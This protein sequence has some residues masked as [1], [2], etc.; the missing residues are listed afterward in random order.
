MSCVR[1]SVAKHGTIAAFVGGGSSLSCWFRRRKGRFRLLCFPTKEND[2]WKASD[3]Q[4]M[5]PA[6]QRQRHGG[7]GRV[8]RR[9]PIAPRARARDPPAP[10]QGH[11]PVLPMRQTPSWLRPG[12]RRAS[13]ASSGFRL[14]EGRTGR[15]DAARG[16]PGM[17]RRGRLRAV[18]GAGQPVHQGF[19][20]G[21][22]VADDGR[23]PEDGRRFPSY[24]V[25]D[26]GRR[27][28]SGR[29]TRQGVDALAVRR[30]DGDR[31]GRDQLQEG[32]R[33]WPWSSTTSSIG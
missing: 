17:R 13:L 1:F 12:R 30:P 18:G 23:E 6:S 16:L 14:L 25:E 2:N 10:A 21:V 11:A 26:R 19:R 5:Q 31:R 28:P 8:H 20:G 15:L 29:R 33:T 22:R 24:R 7:R 4:H 9:L 27:R 3:G 32:P